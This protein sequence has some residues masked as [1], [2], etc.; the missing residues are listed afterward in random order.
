MGGHKLLILEDD[1][2]AGQ[3][4]RSIAEFA[5]VEVRVAARPTEFFRHLQD[6]QPSVIVLDLILPGEDGL[7]VMLQLA[8]LSCDVPLI[9]TSGVGSRV[10][11]AAARSAQEHDLHVL[12]VL[13]KPFPP[14]DLRRLLLHSYSTKMPMLRR[15]VKGPIPN[16]EQLA[17]A[18]E[19]QRLQIYLQ[20]KVGCYSNWLEGFE[21]LVRWNEPGIGYVSPEHFVPLAEQEGLID[22]LTQQVVAQALDWFAARRQEI[23]PKARDVY[24]LM[25]TIRLSI[26]ISALSLVN[27][28]LLDWIES[29]CQELNIPTSMITFELTESSAMAQAVE[30]LSTLTRLCVKGF[31]LS[32]DDFGTGFSSMLQLVRLPFSEIK[33]DRSFVM[34]AHSSRESRAVIKSIIELGHS[35]GLRTTAEG[36]EDEKTLICL[37]QAG[38]DLAQGYFIARPMPLAIADVWLSH[39]L[40]EQEEMRLAALYRLNI[41]DTP[42]EERFDR[43]TRMAQKHFDVPVA[44]VVL[45][46]RDRQWFKS[47][48]GVEDTHTDRSISFCHYAILGEDIL[49]IPD[50]T[51]DPRV[52]EMEPVT[53][54]AHVRFYAGCPLTV[55]GGHRV[56]TLCIV[57]RK[58]RM[59]DEADAAVLRKLARLVEAELQPDSLAHRDPVTALLNGVGFEHAA[60]NALTSCLQ[61][62]LPVTLCYFRLLHV[63]AGTASEQY[64]ERARI[65]F[66]RALGEYL[67]ESD[68]VA[69][70]R[71]NDFAVL[72][73]DATQEKGL[74]LRDFVLKRRPYS[75][76]W[77]DLFHCFAAVE[78]FKAEQQDTLPELLKRA[79]ERL[80]IS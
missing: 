70:L 17:A 52:C 75:V 35:L 50:T 73:V 15:S 77:P 65:A 9:I 68:I 39:Y 13:A 16:A 4:M 28:D 54:A 3:T 14:S 37:Q 69:R 20:P 48:Q 76:Q 43:I 26:N 66:A 34:T 41:L 79:E 5:G 55:A 21:V 67:R 36:V 63:Q 60:A 58:P 8:S 23:N 47:Y 53:G 80:D 59:F 27:T 62:R 49:V 2:M 42:Q 6:W 25:Q 11:E 22:P 10:L 19:Q 51:L 40:A 61:L 32:I 71:G 31:Q 1:P 18:I 57:D 7:Q 12:G 24:S 64:V 38:C 78:V 74:A 44:L 72:L 56:G 33:I 30:S 29:R 46:D 45:I